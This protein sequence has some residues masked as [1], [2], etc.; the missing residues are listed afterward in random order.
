MTRECGWTGNWWN[1]AGLPHH[2]NPRVPSSPSVHDLVCL[3]RVRGTG[4]FLTESR[5]L[6]WRRSSAYYWVFAFPGWLPRGTEHAVFAWERKRDH[7]I[8]LVHC[9]VFNS[10]F[11]CRSLLRGRPRSLFALLWI[12]TRNGAVDLCARRVISDY[13]SGWLH[14]R[15]IPG[16]SAPITWI[17]KR[18][19]WSKA[20]L[21]LLV[22]PLL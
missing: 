21:W 15:A 5:S 19:C 3:G 16:W 10:S 12:K 2:R 7:W 17:W 8:G 14:V 9:W 11:P 13:K 6:Q 4:Y 22:C 20:S 1:T 18:C